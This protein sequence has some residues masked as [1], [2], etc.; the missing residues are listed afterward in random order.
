MKTIN[1]IL[2]MAGKSERFINNQ[3]K[4]MYELNNRP[5]FT[6][7]LETILSV[8]EIDKVIIVVSN[9]LKEQ[10]KSIIE[11]NNYLSKKIEYVIGGST[12]A[13]SVRNAIKCVDSN[14]VLIHDAA[15]PLV[16][17]KD[18]LELISMMSK[19]KCGTLYHKIYDTIKYVD[20]DIVKTVNRD[21]LK[22]VSTPQFFSSDLYKII[23]NPQIEDSLITD[24][25]CLFEKEDICFV[26]ESSNNGKVT[27]TKDLD[28]I[29]YNNGI[30]KIGHSFDFHPF[31]INRKLILGGI[32]IKFD[33]GLL[34][35]SDADVVYHVVAE[36]IMGALG[37]GDLG[38]LFPDTDKTFKDM[39]SDYFV[40][41]VMKKL[42]ESKYIIQNIDLIIY[43][44][45]PNLKDY[46]VKI[47]NNIKKL[48]R[49]EYINVKAT[50]LEKKGLIGNGL[51]I[52]SESVVLIKK[53][54]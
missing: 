35:H 37:M 25:L 10:I 1:A 22:A 19:Y 53:T 16:T 18:I 29:L 42:D 20:D 6:Y 5:L 8:D 40:K 30:Y 33:K 11:Q 41:E 38:T 7:S 21:K 46:K 15:R 9:I 23:L 2:L 13:E 39:P 14:Y 4:L 47:A 31:E 54:K 32:E 44:E 49:C 51:G 43:L 45:R 26:E 48:T 27:T 28:K 12:R 36:S 34:G 52:A 3:N 17:K 24:E 50:T